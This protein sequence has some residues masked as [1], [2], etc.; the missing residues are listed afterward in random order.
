[1]GYD[2]WIQQKIWI[3]LYLEACSITQDSQ[4][5]AAGNTTTSILYNYILLIP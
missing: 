4:Y 1:M 2:D 5:M 3:L